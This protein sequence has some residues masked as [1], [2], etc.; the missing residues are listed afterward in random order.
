MDDV[1]VNN[2]SV[3]DKAGNHVDSF[4]VNGAASDET[5]DDI[6]NWGGE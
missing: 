3:G 4:R 1:C 2:A 5:L 6:D